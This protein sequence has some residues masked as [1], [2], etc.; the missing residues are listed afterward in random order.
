MA[1]VKDVLD[2]SWTGRLGKGIQEMQALPEEEQERL[3]KEWLEKEN[4]RIRARNEAEVVARNAGAFAARVEVR[5][6][7]QEAQLSPTPTAE[8]EP[9]SASPFE[10]MLNAYRD[11]EGEGEGRTELI[12]RLYFE[13]KSQGQKRLVFCKE[14]TLSAVDAQAEGDLGLERRTLDYAEAADLFGS[15]EWKLKGWVQGRQAYDLTKRVNVM[16]APGYV[17]PEKPVSPTRTEEPKAPVNPLD[18]LSGLFGVAKQMREAMGI[19]A[20]ESS[21]KMDAVQVAMI[22]QAAASAARWE[23]SE[24]HRR[25]LDDLRERHRTALEDAERKGMERGK[26]EAERDLRHEYERKIWDLEHQAKPE[27]EPS[28]VS[29]VVGAL[30][31]PDGV[32]SLVGAVLANLNAP[33]PQPPRP[34]MPP[35]RPVAVNPAQQPVPFIPKPTATPHEPTRAQHIEALDKL[36]YTMSL[37]EEKAEETPGDAAVLELIQKLGNYRASGMAEGSLAAWWSEWPQAG[38]ICDALIQGLEAQD[39]PEP[40]TTPDPTPEEPMDAKALFVQRLNEGAT[41]DA[42]LEELRATATPEELEQLKTVARNLPLAMMAGLLG[43]SQHVER[44]GILRDRLVA[45]PSA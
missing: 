10:E 7:L 30:G 28:L 12:M 24:K 45:E 35:P 19:G 32:S 14:H 43:A 44:I 31:G 6:A 4:E 33:K 1:T 42:I 27:A 26:A 17:P 20:Q 29:E 22:Q 5:K 3:R 11:V 16:P 8:P 36:G 23:E 9:E 39:E 25:E 13:D 15:Y 18:Q 37:L 34:P 41:D 38:N 2:D 40:E 21:G